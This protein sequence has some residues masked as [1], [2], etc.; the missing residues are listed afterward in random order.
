MTAISHELPN[1]DV[2]HGLRSEHVGASESE[3][4]LGVCKYA[5]PFSLYHRKRGTIPEEELSDERVFW[6]THMEA[7]IAMGLAKQHHLRVKKA[8]HY[9][10]NDNVPGA[11]ASL[12]YTVDCGEDGFVPFEIK[13]VDSFVFLEE[14]DRRNGVIVPPVHID[15]QVQHQMMVSGSPY[16]YLGVL[17]GGNDAHLIKCP[18]HEKIQ[19]ALKTVIAQFWDQV[20]NDVEPATDAG[21]LAAAQHAW[22]V[23]NRREVLDLTK[24]GGLD[25]AAC[26]QMEKYQRGALLVKQG[27]NMKD[28]AKLALLGMAKNADKL[29]CSF[30]S[31]NSEQKPETIEPEKVVPQKTIKARR[32][33]LAYPNKKAKEAAKKDD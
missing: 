24:D 32:N 26:D 9:L 5:T 28:E 18:P 12:D 30:G 25:A 19:A 3:A 2:W 10:T 16:G 6:G 13:N 22:L 1:E 29:V 14:W 33:A 15:I 23:P 17:I 27:E 20:A 31:F 11:G 7:T 8:R 4:L 21:D